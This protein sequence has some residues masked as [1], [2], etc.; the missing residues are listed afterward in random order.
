MGSQWYLDIH[1]LNQMSDR[2]APFR[3][4]L[5]EQQAPVSLLPE[6]LHDLQMIQQLFPGVR[7]V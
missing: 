1:H 2:T 3:K 6:I 5:F 4:K 7:L